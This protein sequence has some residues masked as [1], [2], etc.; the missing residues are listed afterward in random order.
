MRSELPA[1]VAIACISVL[2]GVV[3][4]EDRQPDSPLSVNRPYS[5]SPQVVLEQRRDGRFVRAATEFQ[6]Q[7][8]HL[9]EFE[10]SFRKRVSE[11]HDASSV[12]LAPIPTELELKSW[13]DIDF[14]LYGKRVLLMDVYRPQGLKHDLPA[15]IF[16]HGG[17]W[18][19]G[20]HHDYRP[21]AMR[22]AALGYVTA[23]VEF[24]LAGEAA[25]PAAV[26]DL[27]AAVRYLRANALRFNI[28]K[29]WIGMIGGSS[30]GHL[31]LLTGF[32]NGK[33]E[34]E[35]NGGNAEQSSHLQFV[36][37]AYGPTDFTTPIY[38]GR[39]M[40]TAAAQWI[41]QPFAEAPM[42]YVFASPIHHV[43]R[44]RRNEIPPTLFL[45]SFPPEPW[46]QVSTTENWLKR[47]GIHREVH[48]VQ[49]PHGFL[50]MTPYQK[51]ALDSLHNFVMRVIKARSGE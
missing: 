22:T 28:D 3:S 16:V 27:K 10:V 38:C 49:A 33:P 42:R 36:A 30:G 1:S 43:D 14:A 9:Q 47:C 35:G 13:K 48:E 41:A 7:R 24:R 39:G 25:F 23:T 18:K 15:I 5:Q 12:G 20:T 51:Q 29:E 2:L 46:N 6:T 19:R 11:S 26:H 17:G 45:K 8:Q 31:S 44:S 50:L 34:F 21:A 4:A 40:D 32:T 37:S